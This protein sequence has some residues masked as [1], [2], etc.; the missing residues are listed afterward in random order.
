M[1]TER[2]VA[3]PGPAIQMD[4]RKSTR[5]AGRVHGRP[6]RSR[7]E[8]EGWIRRNTVARVGPYTHCNRHVLFRLTPGQRQDPSSRRCENKK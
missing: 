1:H 5:E 4:Q 2:V 3:V 8:G 7:G 6:G